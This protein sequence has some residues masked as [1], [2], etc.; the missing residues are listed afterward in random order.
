MLKLDKEIAE[1]TLLL[2]IE[3]VRWIYLKGQVKECD[4]KT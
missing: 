4:K 2:N 1:G 3:C